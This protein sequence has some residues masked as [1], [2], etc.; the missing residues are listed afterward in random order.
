MPEIFDE[1]NS[2]T[3]KNLSERF[4]RQ[5]EDYNQQYHRIYT[6]RLSEMTKNL[7]NVIKMKWKDEYP[8]CKLH[9]LSEENY[10]KCIVIGTIFKNMKLKP[11]V[12]KQLCEA[13]SLVPQPIPDHFTDESDTLYIE[14]DLQRFE[15]VVQE[16]FDKDFN[17]KRLITGVV[18]ALFGQY[19][20]VKSK[21]IVMDYVFP[22]LE[23]KIEKPLINDDCYIVFM[24]GLNF[25]NSENRGLKLKNM[26]D[27]IKGFFG[28]INNVDPKRIVRIIIAGGAIKNSSNKT[29]LN[30]FNKST[31]A[32]ISSNNLLTDAIKSLDL[33]LSDLSQTIDVDLMPGQNDPSNFVLPQ[34]P[35]H[36][37]LFPQTIQY[38]SFNRVSNPYEFE[39]AEMRI[40]GTSGEPINNVLNYTDIEEPI[41]ALESCLKWGHLA[42]SAPDTLACFPYYDQDPFIIQNFPHV[43]F[44]GNQKKFDT[45]IVNDCGEA[46]RIVCVPDFSFTSS[47]CL[48]NLKSL[49]C[50][51]MVFL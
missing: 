26:S 38:K 21:F 14:D 35:L 15:L 13:S 12:L 32:P 40:L 51:E 9:R 10:E 18:C 27:F 30:N 29:N 43:V 11:S 19:D 31:I 49:E 39:I 44:A 42:P 50:T 22:T 46:V 28:A 2:E 36:H 23:V 5:S 48:L 47:I 3:Y 4:V 20:D 25:V 7:M 34:K 41:E 37:C 8:V 6:V 1:R 45:K 16:D 33:F 17:V 24:S